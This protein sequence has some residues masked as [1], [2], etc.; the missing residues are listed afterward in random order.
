MATE[1]EKGE[2]GREDGV[3]GG[4]E[5]SDC[6]RVNVGMAVRLARQLDTPTFQP[7]RI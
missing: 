7:N 3:E 6:V 4:Q 1:E 5:G 2:E